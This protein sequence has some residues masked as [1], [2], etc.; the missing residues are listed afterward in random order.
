MG[1]TSG[2]CMD[3]FR[4][5]HTNLGSRSIGN[6][7]TGGGIV[8]LMAAFPLPLHMLLNPR[9]YMFISRIVQRKPEVNSC[10]PVIHD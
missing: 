7:R 3:Y 2:V 10:R 1:M 9:T 6:E 8:I 4:D 5:K